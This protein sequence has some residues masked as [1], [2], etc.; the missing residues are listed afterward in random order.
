MLVLDSLGFIDDG[1]YTLDNQHP[2]LPF[3]YAGRELADDAY[4]EGT[5]DENGYG[6]AS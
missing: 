3:D 1:I 4:V 2:V 6:F 5:Y